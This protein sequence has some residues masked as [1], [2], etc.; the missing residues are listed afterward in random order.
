MTVYVSIGNSDDKLSQ[1]E[2][3]D[4]IEA[5][6]VEINNCNV[7]MH[8]IWFS[9]PTTPYQNACYCFDIDPWSASELKEDL[10][11]IAE[12]YRQDSITWAEAETEFIG[13]RSE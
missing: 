1:R 4:F 2:W 11:C 7:T 13:G 5:V 3:A 12:I 6:R 8:G 10:A 9:S